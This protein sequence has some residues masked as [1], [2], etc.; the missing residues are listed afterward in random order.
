VIKKD[1]DIP[2]MNACPP[3]TKRKTKNVNHAQGPIHTPHPFTPPGVVIVVLP[4]LDIFSLLKR[5]NKREEREKPK[6]PAVGKSRSNSTRAKR[7]FY[8]IIIKRS[9]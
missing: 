1:V 2:F 7:C 4:N 9:S 6:M 8:V 3:P 5:E